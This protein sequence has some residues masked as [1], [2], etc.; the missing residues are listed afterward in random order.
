MRLPLQIQFSTGTTGT[1]LREHV[2]ECAL[3]SAGVLTQTVHIRAEHGACN[4]QKPVLNFV[5]HCAVDVSMLPLLL[6]LR[7]DTRRGS[8]K[9]ME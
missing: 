3:A 9:E 2:L 6:S 7:D 1:H 4:A 8:T 5:F